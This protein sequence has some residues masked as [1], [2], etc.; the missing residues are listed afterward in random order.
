MDKPPPKPKPLRKHESFL[1]IP[2]T[3]DGGIQNAPLK[4]TNKS[5]P[6]GKLRILI[7]GVF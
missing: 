2:S 6:T 1:F 7:S 4:A 3:T 5:V